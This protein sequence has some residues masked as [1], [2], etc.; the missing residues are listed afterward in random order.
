MDYIQCIARHNLE[1]S[2][3]GAIDSL[4]ETL[5]KK[6]R[7]LS[8]LC[9][10]T[11]TNHAIENFHVIDEQSSDGAAD[12][13]S[14]AYC[15]SRSLSEMLSNLSYRVTS[16]LSSYSD[17]ARSVKL[18]ALGHLS[19]FT[20]TFAIDDEHK[21]VVFFN[22]TQPHY[23][24][25]QQIQKDLLF[26]KE[27][28]CNVMRH[29]STRQNVFR[30]SLHL[31]LNISNKRDPETAD[32]LT[33]MTAYSK[34]LA[35]LLASSFPIDHQFIQ[36]MQLYASFHD[37]GK[38]R[39]PDN[40]LFCNRRYTV[41]ERA[42]MAQHVHYGADIINDVIERLNFI[43]PNPSEVTFLKNII[44]HHHERYDGLGYPLQLEGEAIPLEARIVAIADVFDALLSKR[45]YK[46][47]WP[48]DEVKKYM[49]DESGKAFDP[50]CVHI[51]LRHFEQFAEIYRKNPPEQ[52]QPKG[53]RSLLLH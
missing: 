8:R 15:S 6:Y 50:L 22:S 20:A 49:A 28:I 21:A 11:A 41:E 1:S 4:F 29:E 24:E 25:G 23:F 16:D 37:I 36:W 17:N 52:P 14:A 7:Y 38:Y 12:I 42:I 5:K 10:S 27:L 34:L 18:R 53:K 51:L 43:K 40:V 48:I 47:A 30:Q 33:R 2:A 35:E 39:I 45:H 26:A 46:P 31:A 19:S 9:I 32:H 44:S 13:A 3:I